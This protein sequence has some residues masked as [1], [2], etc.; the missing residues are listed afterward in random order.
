MRLFYLFILLVI[1][2]SQVK[3]GCGH[4]KMHHYCDSY[5]SVCLKRKKNCIIC[6]P[7]LCPDRSFCCVRSL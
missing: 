5:T 4:Y 6:K 3:P 7:G 2:I 1:I